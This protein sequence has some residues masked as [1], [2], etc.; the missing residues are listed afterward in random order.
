MKICFVS[1]SAGLGGAE[2]VLLESIELLHAQGTECCALMPTEGP[3]C[4]ELRKLGIPVAII[5][6]PMWMGRGKASFWTRLKAALNLVKDTLLA[7]WQV[8]RWKCDVV[9]SNTATVCVGAFAARLLGRP[10]VWHLEEFG[11]EDQGLSFLFGQRFSLSLIERLSSR[12]I[13]LSSALARKYEQSIDPSKITIVY[14]SMHRALNG[15]GSSSREDSSILRRTDGFRCVLVGALIEGKGQRDAVLAL[16]RLKQEGI[17]AELV[18][19]GRGEAEY[20]RS[21]AELVRANGLENEVI[22][23]EQ[24]KNSLP[25]MRSADAVLICS[26]SEAFGRVTIEG[27]F[28]GRPVVGARSG[29]TPEL[30]KEGV[31]GLLY[32]QGDCSDLAAKIEHLYKNPGVAAELGRN[33]QS[34]VE[35]YFTR[36]RCTAELVAVLNAVCLPTA[37]AMGPAPV[38]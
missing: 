30:I 20:Q 4:Q 22:F 25:V 34:W 32:A 2:R 3:F 17:A 13:C 12:C 5:S 11:F 9:Y 33:A 31:S 36:E 21:L 14:P 1:H 28:S 10:H 16:A 29:A 15:E 35:S 37:K 6:Y 19:V 18:I 27:M 26:K 8:S 24:V 23:I 38:M 7:A